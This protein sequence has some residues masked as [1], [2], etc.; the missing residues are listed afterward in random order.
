MTFYGLS[1]NRCYCL[2]VRSQNL[3]SSFLSVF[4]CLSCSHVIILGDVNTSHRT[5]D[6]C[7]PSDIVSDDELEV[8]TIVTSK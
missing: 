5:I 4:V 6:H 7:D 2:H 8:Y 1:I 3:S